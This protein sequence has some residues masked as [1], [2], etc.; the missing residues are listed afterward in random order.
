MAT[1][2]VGCG[3]KLIGNIEEQLP[4][5]KVVVIE[6]PQVIEARGQRD[7]IKGHPNVLALLAG[8]FVHDLDP[9]ALVGLIPPDIT[10]DRVLPA[11]DEMSTVGSAYLAEELGLPGATVRAAEIFRDKLKLREAA[12]AAGLRNPR[13]REIHDLDGLRSAASELAGG[14]LV[15]KPTGRS[16]SQGVVLLGPDDDLAEAWRH[17]TTAE[18]RIKIDPPPFTRYLVEER[19]YGAEIS[20]ECL[21]ADGEVV[22]GNITG[23]HVLPGPFPVEVG[24][25][26]PAALSPAT[27]KE[28]LDAMRALVDATGFAYGVLHCEWI[29]TA[30]GPALVECAGRIPG[31]RITDLMTIAYDAPFMAAYATLMT[32]R[33]GETTMPDAAAQVSAIKFLTAPAAGVV[34]EIAGLDEAAAAPG[35][36]AAQVTVKVGAEVTEA[37]ASRDRIGHVLAV[38]ADHEQAWERVERAAE[39][40]EVTVR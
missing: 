6:H 30:D 29:L 16:G 8:D 40:I 10:I 1:L 17:T 26:V 20:V 19:L 5:E 33:P 36:H 32:G 39:L 27:E 3:F 23:K 14:G 12:H 35:V 37:R 18:G 15:V 25:V 28:L 4:D 24:H 11:T 38:G 9:R 22:F 2:V 13:W 31:D 7:K 21:V 34:G